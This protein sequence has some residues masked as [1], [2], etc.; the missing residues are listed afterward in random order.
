MN[1]PARASAISIVG[2]ADV[3]TPLSPFWQDRDGNGVDRMEYVI[4]MLT[5]MGI[6]QWSD[7]QP[8]LD[9]FERMDVDGSGHLDRKDLEMEARMQ[10]EKEAA[11][12]RSISLKGRLSPKNSPSTSRHACASAS[13]SADS[14]VTTSSASD[15]ES[16]SASLP[17]DPNASI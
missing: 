13:V 3:S 11:A 16:A 15:S 4:G 8:L 17:M 2:P 7:V 1:Q 9:A 12:K 5:H 10:A 14:V 6:L